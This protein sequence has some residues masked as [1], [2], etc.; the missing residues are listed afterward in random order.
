MTANKAAD[1]TPTANQSNPEG[2]HRMANGLPGREAILALV[3]RKELY[4]TTAHQ[5]LQQLC[6]NLEA[7]W[8]SLLFHALIAMTRLLLNHLCSWLTTLLRRKWKAWRRVRRKHYSLPNQE[9]VVLVHNWHQ[10][11]LKTLLLATNRQI[12]QLLTT[13]PAR[14]APE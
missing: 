5:L 12:A 3:C 2:S 6:L 13:S 1:N 9:K 10:W 14:Y 11:Q 8:P 4:M 7:A